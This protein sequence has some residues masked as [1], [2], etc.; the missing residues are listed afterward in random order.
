MQNIH[1]NLFSKACWAGLEASWAVLGHL[2]GVLRRLGSVLGS[3][4]GVLKRLGVDLGPSWKRLNAAQEPQPMQD[5]APS[6]A[7][8]PHKRALPLNTVSSS[9][10]FRDT[11]SQAK[12]ASRINTYIHIYIYSFIYTYKCISM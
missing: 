10:G 7:R 3:R 8:K 4:R 9:G 12:P 5:T 2:G 1:Q 6:G 11:V